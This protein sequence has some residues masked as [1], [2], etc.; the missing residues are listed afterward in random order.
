MDFNSF[1][2]VL[3][4]KYCFEILEYLFYNKQVHFNE[5]LKITKYGSNASRL[6]KKL[7]S[8]KILNRNVINDAK[9]SVLYFLSEDGKIIV[10]I[11]IKL[12]DT[13]QGI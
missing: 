3:S 6:L 5:I 13:C 10:E 4:Y 11:I 7:E 1:L 12:K 2:K 8:L 9:R